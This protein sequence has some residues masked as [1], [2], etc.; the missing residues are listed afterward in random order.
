MD[1]RD[2]RIRFS[3]QIKRKEERKKGGSQKEEE[4]S[5]LFSYT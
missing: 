3:Y 5:I 4:N 1:W 2:V